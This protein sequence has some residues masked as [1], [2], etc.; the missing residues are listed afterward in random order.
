MKFICDKQRLT[1]AVSI[2]QRAVMVNPNHP[3]LECIKFDGD[4]RDG[5]LIM[6]GTSSDMHIVHTMQCRVTEGGTVALAS[7][8]F[9]EIIRRMPDGDVSVDTNVSTNVTVIKSGSSVFSIQG[10][11]CITFPSAPEMESKADFTLE[12]QE[13]KSV[14]RK[15]IN[16]TMANPGKRPALSGD[17]F[18]IKKSVLNVVASDGRRLAAVEIPLAEDIDYCR[19]VLPGFALKEIFKVL[20]DEGSVKISSGKNHVLFDFGSFL[21]YTRIIIGD[22]IRYEPILNSTNPIHVTVKNRVISESL[23]RALLIINEDST[24]TRESRVPVKLDIKADRINMTCLTG[25]GQTTDTFAAE[26]DGGDLTIGFNCKFLLDAFRACD[27]DVL[28]IDFSTP[29]SGCFIRTQEGRMNATFMVLPVK[30]NS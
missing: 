19:F 18:E 1:E 5:T 14:I 23:E 3:I 2:V 25:K 13:L 6:S 29:L 10:L 9:G 22:F 16:F 20:S 26:A 17:L 27:M 4:A 15:T 8:M 11:D 28:K 7:K 12:Q 24:P 21:F 30:I